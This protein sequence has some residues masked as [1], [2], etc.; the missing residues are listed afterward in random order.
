[1]NN[2]TYEPKPSYSDEEINEIADWMN[3]LT[4]DQIFF[5]RD[6]YVA[7][8]AMQTIHMENLIFLK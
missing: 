4:L 1:M 2:E 8:I 6:S 3:D 7:F 5:L